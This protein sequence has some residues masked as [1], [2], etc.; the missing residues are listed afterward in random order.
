MRRSHVFVGAGIA[1]ALLLAVPVLAM[2]LGASA[3]SEVHAIVGVF[4]SVLLAIG[5]AAGATWPDGSTRSRPQ[6]DSSRG[7]YRSARPHAQPAAPAR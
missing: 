4:G 1:G 6:A 5:A 3:P 2:V 7:R